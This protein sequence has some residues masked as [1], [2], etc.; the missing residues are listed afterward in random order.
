MQGLR[1]GML[2]LQE[3]LEKVAADVTE[4]RLQLPW[5]REAV[6]RGLLLEERIAYIESKARWAPAAAVPA[7]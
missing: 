6:E 3:T 7:D 2:E 5:Q 1:Q 4:M